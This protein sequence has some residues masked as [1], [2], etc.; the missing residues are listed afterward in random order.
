ME[1]LSTASNLNH[2]VSYGISFLSLQF[3]RQKLKNDLNRCHKL[4][5]IP[6]LPECPAALEREDL[7]YSSSKALQHPPESLDLPYK[8]PTVRLRS[9]APR[10]HCQD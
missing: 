8:D 7:N 5:S 4:S 6:S 3:S 1:N 2:G 9:Q 10:G